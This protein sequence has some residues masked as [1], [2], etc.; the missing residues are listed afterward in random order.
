[1]KTEQLSF[2]PSGTKPVEIAQL[3]DKAKFFCQRLESHMLKGPGAT[4]ETVKTYADPKWRNR[5]T[6]LEVCLMLHVAGMLSF[7]DRVLVVMELFAVHKKEG[8]QRAV[9]DMRHINGLFQKAPWVGLASPTA[10]GEI[11]LGP[12]VREGQVLH[13]F[14]GDIPD[15][16]YRLRVPRSLLPYFTTPM[17][18]YEE[19]R[20]YAAERGIIISAPPVGCDI[21]A[22]QVL[23]MGWS[24]APYLAET[25]LEA[26][27]RWIFGEAADAGRIVDRGIPAPLGPSWGEGVAEFLSWLYMDDFLVATLEFPGLP[28]D[29]TK[30]STLQDRVRAGFKHWGFPLHKEEE[31]EGV[32]ESIGISVSKG[33]HHLRPLAEKLLHLMLATTWACCVPLVQAEEIRRIVGRWTWT[34]LTLRLSYSIFSSVYAFSKGT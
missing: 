14:V 10:V 5:K 13:S 25:C 18:R 1:M 15:Y 20:A 28:W 23:P 3:S 33:P 22:M 17:V 24:W 34:C 11:Y 26:V 9:W 4:S 29:E 16:F 7:T 21:P 6:V 8:Q 19:L 31:G 32:R 12:E 30:G 2:P 27:F